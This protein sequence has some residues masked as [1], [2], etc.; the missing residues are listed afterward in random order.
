MGGSHDQGRGDGGKD[1]DANHIPSIMTPINLLT[2][3]LNVKVMGRERHSPE[4]VINATYAVGHIV[5][6]DALN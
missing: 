6:K 3:S 1:K 2:R 5:I 4:K